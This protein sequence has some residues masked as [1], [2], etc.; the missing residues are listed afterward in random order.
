[1]SAASCHVSSHNDITL[2]LITLAEGRCKYI[3]IVLIRGGE[4]ET[5][6]LVVDVRLA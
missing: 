4:A 2:V 1:M 5:E 3:F 6:F